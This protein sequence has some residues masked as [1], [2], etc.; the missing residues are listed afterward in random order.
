MDIATDIPLIDFSM[1]ANEL[2]SG[3]S[4]TSP[5]RQ[6][7]ELDSLN[8]ACSDIGF[9][10]LINHAVP[11][12]QIQAVREAIIEWF[13]RPLTEKSAAIVEQHNYRGYIPLGM[14]TPNQDAGKADLYEAYKLHTEISASDPV[15]VDCDLYGPNRWPD[16][17]ESLRIA[18]EQYWQSMDL[19]SVVLLKCFARLLKENPDDMLARFE[20]PPT[21]MTLLHYPPQQQADQSGIHPH[22]DTDVFTLLYP[23]AIGGL[24]LR[25]REGEWIEATAPPGA[26]IVNVGNMLETWSGGRL[27]STPHLVI[28]STCQERYSFPYFVVPAHDVLVEPLLEPKT[29]FTWV[30][31]TAGDVSKEVWR[32]NWPDMIPKYDG[33]NLG[34]LQTS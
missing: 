20:K 7:T 29:E 16:N 34:N 12:D 10:A 15:C 11:Q 31:M 8:R 2:E 30:A 27:L 6:G 1:L 14:F 19:V 23:D 21:N 32:T 17:A 4:S 28:N 33:L 22:R 9:F 18:V 5:T 3:Q 24:Q 26:L 13:N 25:T